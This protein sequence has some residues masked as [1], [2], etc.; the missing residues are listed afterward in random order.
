MS[1]RSR[2]G[3]RRGKPSDVAE[4]GYEHDLKPYLLATQRRRGRQGRD[5]AEGPRELIYGFD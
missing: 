2:L 3:F 5:L 1:L 4:R